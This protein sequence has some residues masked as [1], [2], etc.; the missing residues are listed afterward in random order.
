MKINVL[1]AYFILLES[2]FF[3]TMSNKALLVQT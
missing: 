3:M 2:E 1:N